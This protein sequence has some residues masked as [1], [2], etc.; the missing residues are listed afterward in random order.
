MASAPFTKGTQHKD[1]S[2]L[3]DVASL[4]W[5]KEVLWCWFFVQARLTR[6][7]ASRLVLSYLL[8]AV[9]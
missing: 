2:L 7:A 1:H 6:L 9:G 4:V 5:E 8:G 3:G